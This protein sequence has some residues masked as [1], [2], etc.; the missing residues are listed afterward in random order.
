MTAPGMA[1]GLVVPATG[2]LT[3]TDDLT[4]ARA[5]VAIV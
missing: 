1:C 2:S 3:T 4:T 5:A